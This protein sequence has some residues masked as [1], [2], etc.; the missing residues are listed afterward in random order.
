VVDRTLAWAP[1]L[2][3]S[4]ALAELEVG[5]VARNIIGARLASEG[6]TATA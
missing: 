2:H 4:G 1:G 3:V 5:P 6:V